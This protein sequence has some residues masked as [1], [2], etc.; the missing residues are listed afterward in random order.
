MRGIC[1]KACVKVRDTKAKDLSRLIEAS[2]EELLRM[3]LEELPAHLE[4]YRQTLLLFHRGDTEGLGRHLKKTDSLTGHPHAEIVCLCSE[5]RRQILAGKPD[6]ALMNRLASNAVPS[7]WRG[8][9]CVL[10]AYAWELHEDFESALRL[11]KKA[12]LW[13]TKIGA[14]GKSLRARSNMIANLSNVEPERRLIPEYLYLN[15]EAARLGQWNV[16]ATT[17]LNVSREYQAMG[18]FGVALRY[19]GQAIEACAS[20]LEGQIY[21]L[22]ILHRAHLYFQ[23]GRPLDARA[24]LEL[25]STS[26]FPVVNAAHAELRKILGEAAGAEETRLAPLTWKNRAEKDGKIQ[27]LSAVEE[28]LIAYLAEKPRSKFEIA[29]HLWG[30]DTHPLT[31]ENRLKNLIHRVRKKAPGLIVF[32]QETYFLSDADPHFKKNTG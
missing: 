31:A 19:C 16:V 21:F 22:A 14:H 13:L 27:R 29:D 32:E 5:L 23:T 8:E 18:A 26:D 28:K 10:V 17:F 7:Q 30:A 25:A 20:D 24:D 2:V 12:A 11:H 9:A 3:E 6:V 15:R 4:F 1:R